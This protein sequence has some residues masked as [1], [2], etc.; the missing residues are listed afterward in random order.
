MNDFAEWCHA[1]GLVEIADDGTVSWT[2]AIKPPTSGKTHCAQTGGK[3]ISHTEKLSGS[4]RD[5]RKD[6]SDDY[7]NNYSHMGTVWPFKVCAAKGEGKAVAP[8]AR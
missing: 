6:L 5:A 8:V 4:V 3:K 2:E 1:K 7:K